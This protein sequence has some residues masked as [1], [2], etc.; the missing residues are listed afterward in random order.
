MRNIKA[1]KSAD[2]IILFLVKRGE[3]DA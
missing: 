1:Y 2:K 3:N